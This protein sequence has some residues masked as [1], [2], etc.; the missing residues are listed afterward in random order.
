M[1]SSGLTHFIE[2]SFCLLF[3]EQTLQGQGGSRVTHL[4]HLEESVVGA[5]HC[6]NHV[7][8]MEVMRSD[9]DIL[10]VEPLRFGDRLEL[11]IERTGQG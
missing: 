1:V 3:I 8:T 5:P 9:L 6:L 4:G 7:V 10:K 11:N 2:R